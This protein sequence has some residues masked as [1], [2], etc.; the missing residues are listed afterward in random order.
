MN[1]E[2]KL[3]VEWSSPWSEFV[4]SIRPALMKSPPQLAGEARTGVIPYRGIM[5][6]W[7]AEAALLSALIVLPAQLGMLNPYHPPALPKYDVIYF[8][9]DELP[10]TEDRGG[11]ETG[12]AGS[13]GGKTARHRTQ[14]IRVARGNVPR[15]KVVDAPSL[16]LPQSST[17]V[18]NLLAYKSVPGPPPVEGI[19]VTVPAPSPTQTVVAPTPEVRRENTL[20]APLLDAAVPP[21]PSVARDQLRNAPGMNALVVPPSPS[22]VQR[23]ISAP[24]VPGSQVA[25]VP[26]PVSA[27]EQ[28]S[29]LNSPLTLPSPRVVAPPPTDMTREMAARGPG[30]GPGEP[31]PRQVVPPPVQAGSAASTRRSFG[32]AG[33]Q[34]VAPPPVQWNAATIEHSQVPTLGKA[35]VV[36]PPVQTS[37]IRPGSSVPANPGAAKVVPPPVQ[38]AGGPSA[39]NRPTTG[40]SGGT[41]VVPPP[42]TVLGDTA[43]LGQGRGS[44]GL[45][46]GGPLDGG[47]VV[48]PP[49]HS[50]GSEA[51][52]GIVVSSQPGSTLG[53]PS[54]A[55]AGALTLSPAG[56]AHPGLGGPGTGNDIARG[57]GSGAAMQG[58][59]PGAANEGGG[60]GAD[61]TARNS[62]S[63]YPGEGGAGTGTVAKPA[64][65]GVSVHGGNVI[66]LP[67]IGAGGDAPSVPGR[68]P[69]MKN[70][71][72]DITVEASPR[73]GGGFNFYG[74]LKGDK[75]YS[76]YINTVLG[77]A[78]MQ[79]SD[80][81]SATRPYADDLIA[82]QP[83]RA[84]LP[85]HLKLSRLVISYV[86]DRSG[87]LTNA[88]VLEQTGS[89]DA[90]NQILA[91]LSRWKF[92]PA[93]RGD[94]PV[95]VTAI[96][97][98]DIDTR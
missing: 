41:G 45:G 88:Q 83:L 62:I 23:E 24:P 18:E 7:M 95:A 10:Q 89:S 5:V 31:Q 48:A 22:G 64:L 55:G 37:G 35:N 27:P 77:T 8:S 94:Q 43:A 36:P 86:L 74:A 2:L 29:K 80:P 28:Q 70:E 9:G 90:T 87:S 76:I 52:T 53:K 32:G 16:N 61:L 33:N 59:G 65:P 12:Q 42:P 79:Y 58:E 3:L 98:F 92:R 91:A 97:G 39:R 75:V 69:T 68:S 46:S 67:S 71:G 54:S 81:S 44:R 21:S 78:V 1:R 51:G 57:A 49:S 40:L 96:L 93:F 50:G 56:G 20:V 82:P 26:P 13:S 14:V 60:T 84:D 66:S 34:D 4:T 17:A 11:A 63:P 19:R 15:E 85:G 47:T 38:L 6:T 25:V 72:P 30:F 73:S